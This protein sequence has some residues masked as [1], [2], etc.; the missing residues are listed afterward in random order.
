MAKPT[1]VKRL[2]KGTHLTFTELDANF[3]NLKDATVTVN[4]DT[5]STVSD[6]N[7]S[8]TIA[9]GT[10]LTTSVAGSTLTVNLDNT[11]VTA[12]SYT[13]ANI[14]V[15]AQGRITLASN[16]S[17]SGGLSAVVDDLTPKLGGD[18]VVNGKKITSL[19]NGNIVIDPDGTGTIKLQGQDS[20]T[21]IQVTTSNLIELNARHN[22]EQAGIDLAP[23]NGQL[24]ISYYNEF[25]SI[26]AGSLINMDESS[27]SIETDPNASG[28]VLLKTGGSGYVNLDGPI[29]V[30]TTTG[31]PTTYQNGYFDGMLVTPVGW[32]KITK[33]ASI[34]YLPLYQ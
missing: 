5:G 28:D 14:T 11:A 25:T 3:Q 8:V 23:G 1:I 31:T 16:G 2:V 34:F 32:L 15:D 26:A 7:G 21:Y 6:L 10:A 18:L 27:I 20:S 19:T 12:G 30:R 33:G 17:A 29:K 4:G 9:G 13:N 22:N 24:T